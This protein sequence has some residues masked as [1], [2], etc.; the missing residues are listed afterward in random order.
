[1]AFL[2]EVLMYVFGCK[3]NEN[4]S[5]ATWQKGSK[6][7]Q[8]RQDSLLL[9]GPA[10]PT[11]WA[12]RFLAGD[13]VLRADLAD[14]SGSRRELGWEGGRSRAMALGDLIA[15]TKRKSFTA[16]ALAG[17][18]PVPVAQGSSRTPRRLAWPH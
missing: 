3:T 5:A 13:P 14:G 16:R 18:T 1:M 7:K 8:K 12:R 4:R 15:L 17:V 9:A 10:L 6:W 2:R 11:Y